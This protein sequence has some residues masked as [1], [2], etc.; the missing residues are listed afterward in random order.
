M[1]SMIKRPTSIEKLSNGLRRSPVVA[2]LGPRQCGKTTLA[3]MYGQGRIAAYFDLESRPDQTRLQNPELALSSLKGTVILDEIQSAPELFNVLRVI[4]DRPKNQTR[5][6]ILGSASPELMKKAS[7]TLAGRVEIVELS[8]FKLSEIKT[9]DERQLWLRGGFPRSFLAS[10]DA[11]SAAWREGFIRTF[12]ER[13][14]PQLGISIPAAA[15]RRFW[16]M[17]AHY[18]GQLWNASDLGRA[19]GLSDKTM[20]GYLDILSGTFMI[21]QLMP[22]HENLS[23]RQVKSPKIYFRDSGILHQ[24]LSLEDFHALSGH[25]RVGASWEGFALEQTLGVLKTRQTYFWSTYSGAE[26]DLFFLHKGR[27]YG[28]EF[29]YSEAP[30]VTKSMHSALETLKLDHLWIVYPGNAIY[31]AHKKITALPLKDIGSLKI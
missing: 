23:K 20:R 6:L 31:P 5:F 30:V 11:D 19:M 17:L 12:L 14:I 2:L 1:V 28:M 3:R 16:T 21:R 29:K 9:K 15:M 25:P 4:V 10:S 26:L 7:E 13:D 22:W 18:H 8:G 27:R 24:L